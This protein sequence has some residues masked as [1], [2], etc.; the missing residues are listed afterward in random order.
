MSESRIRVML[1]DDQPIIGEPLDVDDD[2]DG[3]TEND[4]DCDD[5]D[6]TIYPG[7]LDGCDQVDEDCDGELDEDAVD[8]DG[9]EPNDDT[10]TD[11]GTLTTDSVISVSG[12]LHSDDDVDRFV[13]DFEDS[14]WSIFTLN[15]RVSGVP[16]DADYAL[17]LDYLASGEERVGEDSGATTLSITTEDDLF[18]EDGGEYRLTLSANR[19][20]DCSRAYL[21]SLDLE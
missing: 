4:G 2:G 14:S 12:Y 3:A 21:I 9:N 7:A 17:A 11:L 16:S 19:G 20:A 5:A 10:D 8:D 6:G 15:I 18:D 13:F 1:V